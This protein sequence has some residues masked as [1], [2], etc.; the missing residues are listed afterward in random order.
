MRLKRFLA[1]GWPI[2]VLS[3]P[4]AR[5]TYWRDLLAR[6]APRFQALRV[7]LPKE[8]LLINTDG[9][10]SANA[11]YTRAHAVVLPNGGTRSSDA[12]TDKELLAH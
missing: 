1:G 6:V 9:R 10:A 8:V 3:W 7:R 2:V 12:Y 11:P 5:E 4:P